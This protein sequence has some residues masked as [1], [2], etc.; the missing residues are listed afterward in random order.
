[1]SFF[2]ASFN[3]CSDFFAI[4]SEDG[5]HIYSCDPF[6]Q[7]V[8]RSVEGGVRHVE[9]L[10]RCSLCAI[11]PSSNTKKVI[12]WNDR[13]EKQFAEFVFNCSVV[14][15]KLRREHVIIIVEHAIHIY[16]LADTKLMYVTDTMSNP[17]GLCAVSFSGPFVLARLGTKKGEI[18][19][20]TL[21]ERA[22]PK[23]NETRILDR[24]VIEAHET[25]LNCFTLSSDGTKLATASECG[26]LIRVFD[27]KTGSLMQE[28]RR[29]LI[30]AEI[31]CMRF[32]SDGRW[33]ACVSDRGT[34][35]V[36]QIGKTTKNPHSSFR[37]LATLL[38][39][40]FSSEW[41]FAQFD[42]NSTAP[43]VLTFGPRPGELYVVNSFHK[44]F[45][46]V[47]FDPNTQNAPCTYETSSF[48]LH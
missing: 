37:G 14:N 36:F 7:H 42:T 48:S 45:V 5:F 28:M 12:L 27:V 41:S 35:H 34:G 29:G 46:K 15:V 13:E 23:S 38:P 8:K 25:T 40:Y 10:Y 22:D 24:T 16:G 1:M 33:L 47:R 20:E 11:I 17:R 18:V 43:C 32:D 4:G 21:D 30:W 2:E 26:T 31:Y 6:Q 39:K 3:Q 9:L 44:S 19:I